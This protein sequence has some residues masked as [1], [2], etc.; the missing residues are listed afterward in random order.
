[1]SIKSRN[2]SDIIVSPNAT[3]CN[4]VETINK[5]GVRGIFVCDEDRELLGVV[6]DSDIR[7][8][9]L[10]NFDLNASVKTIMKVTPFFIDSDLPL[11]KRKELL[12]K[13]NKML[14]PIVDVQ[15]RVIDF[16]YLVDVLEELLE[17]Q[18]VLGADG[19]DNGI[20]PPG[21]VLVIGG[22]GYI[23]LVLV[24]KLHRMGYKVRVLDLLLY[25]KD[26]LHNFQNDNIEFIRGDCRDEETI[27]QALE[28]VDAVV[29]LGEIVGDPACSVNK[30]FTIE[31]NYMATHKIAEQCVKQNISRFIFASSCSVYG[32]NDNEIDEN[33][34][35]NPVSLYARC[36][37][38]SEKAILS[39]SYNHFRPTILRLATVHG[40]SQRQRFDLVV[41][42]LTIKALAEKKIQVFG[43]S[44][45]RPFIHIDDVCHGIIA[46][47]H[48][49]SKKVGN[50][51]F[52]LGDS[53]ENYQLARVGEIIKSHVSGAE[54][55]ILEDKVDERSYRVSFEKI[56]QHLGFSAEYNIS[57]SVKSF[58]NAYQ[59][60]NQ[61]R[62][63]KDKEYH[64][65]LSF[66]V[67]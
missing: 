55:E 17:K 31:T 40:M 54:L 41:N 34:E 30:D 27:R 23:G 3:I 39:C 66:K 45:W 48:S 61:F 53:R 64:N 44:Q 16:I 24:D 56:K 11:S 51:V 10:S 4:G 25:G 20:L 26:F 7:R 29:H 62:D 32:Q 19:E 50:Q 46:V 65:V 22:A 58:V 57:D 18:N 42:F 8:A 37:I 43:G 38:E 36:K 47:L 33:S 6:M 1:M 60:E 5:N 49:E 2:L 14:A 59:E 63:Y 13:S 28:G 15:K 35:T 12:I 21:K 52:N 9:I 67:G